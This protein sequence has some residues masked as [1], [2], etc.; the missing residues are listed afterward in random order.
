ME[1]R[2]LDFLRPKRSRR[3]QSTALGQKRAVTGSG[4]ELRGGTATFHNRIARLPAEKVNEWLISPQTAPRGLIIAAGAAAVKL[5]WI[6]RRRLNEGPKKQNQNLSL[7][8]D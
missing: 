7:L 6:D 2:R 4:W 3:P 5:L 1:S 8:I